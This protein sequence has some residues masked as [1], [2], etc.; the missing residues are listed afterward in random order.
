M[1]SQ[2][3]IIAYA[4]DFC[5]YLI[6]KIDKGI[7]SI[8]LYGSIVRGDFDEESDID[9][10]IDTPSICCLRKLLALAC[11]K[12]NTNLGRAQEPDT[13]PTSVGGS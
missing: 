3:E 5:S 13:P 9:L 11:E 10:F 1:L 4:M 6:S 12:A 2:N 8:I 7:N